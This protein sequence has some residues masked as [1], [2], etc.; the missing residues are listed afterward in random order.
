MSKK[1]AI[2]LFIILFIVG[3]LMN[4]PYRKY[5][6]SNGIN[7]FGIAD[8]GYSLVAVSIMFLIGIIF[9]IRFFNNVQL[10]VFTIYI[11]YVLHEALS[12]FIPFFG[13]FDFIPTSG[14]DTPRLV[15]K[16]EKYFR[17]HTSYPWVEVVD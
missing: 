17:R 6:F 10:N 1:K 4:N 13:V 5:I 2:I 14:F 7:D 8:S 16:W 9:N 3:F 11:I 12:Y 15:S